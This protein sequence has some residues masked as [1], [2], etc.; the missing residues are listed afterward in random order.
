[1]K[2]AAS[3]AGSA[4]VLTPKAIP[5]TETTKQWN[6]SS[7]ASL[8]FLHEKESFVVSFNNGTLV[9]PFSVSYHYYESYQGTGQKSGAYIFR[10]SV[11]TIA[12]PKKYSTIKV[13]SYV[14]GSIYLVVLL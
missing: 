13:V 5:K 14:E 9:Y 8:Q 3:K 10:P 12:S 1:M 11:H 7:T 2:I 6:V 4:K